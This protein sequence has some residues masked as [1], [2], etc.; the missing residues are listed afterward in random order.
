MPPLPRTPTCFMDVLELMWWRIDVALDPDIIEWS[1]KLGALEALE[2]GSTAI[3]DHH[4]SPRAIEGSLSVI[5]EACA[6]VGVRVNCAYGVTDRH[7]AEGAAAGLAENDRF[8][9]DGGRG[10][11]GLHAAFTCTDDTIAA[12]AEMARAHDVGV[13]VHVA[14]GDVDTWQQLEGHTAD[15]WWLVHGVHLP[16][17]HGLS[18][19]IIH[20]PRSNMNNAVGYSRPRR[21]ANRVGL[22]TDGIGADMLDE[23][24]IAFVKA[25]EDDITTSPDDVWAW[26]DAG[27]ELFPEARD[28]RVTW[29]YEPMDPWRLAYSPGVSPTAVEIE[30]EVVF[31][32]GA[33]TRVDG[34]EIRAK[35]AEAAQRL[36]T[37]LETTK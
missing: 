28:D 35:A 13:H 18:G 4:E 9:A 14:E 3:V 11:V 20:N 15:N 37:K 32:D 2:R 16:D 1:A 33:A 23:F 6:E 7:G 10:M 21:F 24:R 19:T 17:D 31:A 29:T 25:R 27:Y 8:L 30:G 26:L 22:G 34:V 12:A 36:F 5:A